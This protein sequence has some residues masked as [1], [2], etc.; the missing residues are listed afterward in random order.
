MSEVFNSPRERD[1]V[2]SEFLE[3]LALTMKNVALAKEVA[4]LEDDQ[5]D[6]LCR[7]AQGMVSR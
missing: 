3:W 1:R 6:M 5:F 4:E 2:R 7:Y